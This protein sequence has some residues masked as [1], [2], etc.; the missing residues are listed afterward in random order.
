MKDVTTETESEVEP[1]LSTIFKKRAL[2][3]QNIQN[4]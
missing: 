3:K 1:H 4:V 2:L